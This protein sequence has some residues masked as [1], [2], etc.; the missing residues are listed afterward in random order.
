MEKLKKLFLC[1]L[2]LVLCLSITSTAYSDTKFS[3]P[4][5][6]QAMTRH[7]ASKKRYDNVLSKK[8]NSNPQASELRKS[9]A[10][11]HRLY[12]ESIRQFT[13]DSEADD[14][15]PRVIHQIWLGSPVPDR[16]FDWMN[17]WASMN[18]WDY[19]LWTDEDASDYH[20][21]NQ[22]LYDNAKDYGEKSDIL[23]YEILFREGGLYVD[24]DF[25]CLKPDLLTQFN[26]SFDFYVG[27]QPIEHKHIGYSFMIGNAIIASVP[28]H[29]ILSKVIKNMTDHYLENQNKWAV[30]TTGP[31]YFT[32]V[33]LEYLQSNDRKYINIVL[34]PSFFFP[35]AYNEMTEDVFDKNWKRLIK[36]ETAAIHYWTGS[37]RKKKRK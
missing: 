27:F 24:V 35:L 1:P 17:S 30:V 9:T 18:G 34:P 33:I 37:W 23:R 21:Y 22:Y 12:D 13:N 5:F 32:Q 14:R 25:E 16:F 7:G 8:N 3:F 29:P 31:V 26:K 20:L 15:I 36:P 28:G 6:V 11:Y 4:E 10:R 2:I 19:K